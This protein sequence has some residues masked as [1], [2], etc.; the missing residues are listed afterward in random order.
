M[1]RSRTTS[2]IGMMRNKKIIGKAAAREASV[3][4]QNTKARTSQLAKKAV[5][6]ESVSFGLRDKGCRTSHT[7]VPTNR[8][9]RKP[10]NKQYCVRLNTSERSEYRRA[11]TRGRISRVCEYLS[12]ESAV[13]NRKTRDRQKTA[14]EPSTITTK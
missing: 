10:A 14:I 7:N 11:M 8:R 1:I 6:R 5:C 3:P 13:E 4:K 12:L 2:G 9:R